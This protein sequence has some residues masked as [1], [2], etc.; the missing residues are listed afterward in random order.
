MLM[1]IA[2]CCCIQADERE[3]T[4]LENSQPRS[5][6]PDQNSVIYV[7]SSQPQSPNSIPKPPTYDSLDLPPSYNE[8]IRLNV[9]TLVQQ[10]TINMPSCSSSTLISKII[11]PNS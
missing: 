6:Y 4:E 8:A 5:H 11:K 1:C 10:T 7:I 2:M 3:Q 9:S